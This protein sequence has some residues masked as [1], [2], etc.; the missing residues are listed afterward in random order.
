K[1]ACPR[2]HRKDLERRPSSFAVSRGMAEPAEDA[3]GGDGLPP[4]MDEEKLAR[5]MAGFEGDLDGDGDDPKAAARMM[6]KIWETAGLTLGPT[7]EEAFRRME[8]GED[9]E[10]IEA[11][12]GDSLAA[13]DPFTGIPGSARGLRKRLPPAVDPELH[14]F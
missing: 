14:E 10:S 1:P 4:G 5:A 6:R 3:P 2:C 8:A 12:L 7:M 11:D 13:E 9:P